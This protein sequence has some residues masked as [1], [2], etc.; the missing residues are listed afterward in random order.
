MVIRVAMNRISPALLSIII[1]FSMVAG[2][3]ARTPALKYPGK[4]AGGLSVEVPAGWLADQA[5]AN[6]KDRIRRLRDRIR[7]DLSLIVVV[8]G[9]TDTFGSPAE[10]MA[11]G[12]YYAH[13]VAN[14]LTT[15]SGFPEDRIDIRSAGESGA[16][17]NHGG[18]DAQ[19]LNRRVVVSLASPL[20]KVIKPLPEPGTNPGRVLILEPRAG[21]VNRS[22]QRLTAIVEGDSNTALLTVNGISSLIAV[23]KSRIESEIV[24]ENGDNL[25]EVMAWDQSGRFGRDQVKVVYVPPPPQVELTHPVDGDVFNTTISPVIQVNGQIM[26][27]TILRETFLFLNG[28]PRRIEVDSQG[29]FSQPIVLIRE[30]NKLRVEALD[31]FGKTATSPDITV[32]TINMA[33]KD[34]VVFLTWDKPGVDLDLH[35]WGPEGKHT[36]YRALDP[37]DSSEAI[38]GGALDL[39]D[40]DGFGPE[41]F[42]LADGPEG[43]YTIGARYHHSL[44]GTP[45][46]AQVTVVLHPAEPSRRITRI[47]GPF[48]MSPGINS[49]WTVARVSFPHES[50]VSGSSQK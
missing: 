2:A 8:T 4:S 17:V 25:I 19:R 27:K 43:I 50:F 3:K 24:L 6:V 20:E 44:K 18:H 7:N 39:D 41:V 38:P 34:M 46:K 47:F 42:T 15:V 12:Y 45:C 14:Q 36:Y 26:S 28:S 22:Y 48:T 40:K 13:E 31:I 30:K 10:N 37:Y 35:V 1:L 49:N 32:K 5:D 29:R 23:N 9:H 21:T 11:I 16:L 33:P